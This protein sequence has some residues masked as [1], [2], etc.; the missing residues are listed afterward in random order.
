MRLLGSAA[1]VAILA[2]A[3]LLTAHVSADAAEGGRSSVRFGFSRGSATETYAP[4]TLSSRIP[5]AERYHLGWRYQAADPWRAV[6]T[7]ARGA[8]AIADPDFPGTIHQRTETQAL[9]GGMLAYDVLGGSLG[10]GA[11]YA[12]R[13]VEVSSSAKAPGTAP[14]FLFAPWHLF[15]GVTFMMDYRRPLFGPFGLELEVEALPQGFA[16]LG[17]TR[18][19]LPST[20]GVGVHP[21]LTFWGDRFALGYRYERTQSALYGRELSA[22][23][24]S[25]ALSGF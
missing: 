5:S 24:A 23:T 2:A 4:E 13:W 15:H 6:A 17:D 12:A 21:R 18:L 10:L 1:A 9:V 7:L 8:F 3:F 19:S 20:W 16:H 11:G 25:F 22:M 14:A